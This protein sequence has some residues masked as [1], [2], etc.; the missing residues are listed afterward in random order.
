MFKKVHNATK[1][2]NSKKFRQKTKGSFIIKM[3]LKNVSIL[4]KKNTI[5]RINTKRK[6]I[7]AQVKI[8]QERK[9]DGKIMKSLTISTQLNKSLVPTKVFSKK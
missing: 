5:T 9:M 3:N 2:N 6:R 7:R 1:N 8:K 4:K